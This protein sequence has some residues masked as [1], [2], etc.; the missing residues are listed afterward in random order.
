MGRRMGRSYGGVMPIGYVPDT[1]GHI[2]QLPQILRGFQIDNAV[3]WRGVGPEVKKDAFHWRAPDGTEVLVAW[4]NDEFGYSNAAQLPLDA[5]ALAAR[6]E[7]IAR[8]MQS[9]A[10]TSTLLLMNGS[11]HLMPQTGLPAVLE[12][13][14]Q[15]LRD[16]HLHLRIGTLP[17]YID[18]LKAAATELQTRS[19]EMRSSYGAH[20]LP[21]VFSSR[22]WLKQRNAAG[23]ALLTRWTEPA[24]VWAWLLGE[25]Y[26][27]SQVDLAWKFLMHNHPHDSICGCSIDQVH[28]EMMS[29]FAQSEQIAGELAT[30]ALRSLAAK[31]RVSASGGAYLPVVV[32]NAS[33][34]P[35]TE[36]VRCTAPIG[37]SRFAVVNE[38]GSTVPTQVLARRGSELLNQVADKGTG[39]K[40]AWYH[41]CWTCARVH[42]PRCAM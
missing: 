27:Q 4:L 14:N 7:L 33:T 23:E 24:T 5:E 37:F 15:R 40:H 32:F 8:R 19:G 30:R 26:P 11:D 28:A 9:R 34:G 39:F 16:Q 35:R 21:G 6:V 41:H 31:V 3:F 1:F 10:S 18:L 2:A 38:L 42:D 25:S 29:R 36:V 13:A 20:L 17:E 12:A 22:M